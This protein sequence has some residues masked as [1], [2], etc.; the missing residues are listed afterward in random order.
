VR[1]Q[2]VWSRVWRDL[3]VSRRSQWSHRGLQPSLGFA[4]KPHAG[5]WVCTWPSE[6]S[7]NLTTSMC[8]R[9]STRNRTGGCSCKLRCRGGGALS[10]CGTDPCRAGGGTTAPCV[11]ARVC[12]REREECLKHKEARHSK[13]E[14]RPWEAGGPS[15]DANGEPHASVQLNSPSCPPEPR[16]A[17]PRVGGLVASLTT[18]ACGLHRHAGR[19]RQPQSHSGTPSIYLSLTS[20]QPSD[21]PLGRPVGCPPEWRDGESCFGPSV[22][23]CAAR[24]GVPPHNHV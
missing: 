10:T 19:T 21:P 9:C 13:A 8:R 23:A 6:N 22:R 4:G 12:E 24:W 2:S 5:S 14:T 20:L 15:N 16:A 7:D 1:Q 17:H 11:T 3:A 18:H